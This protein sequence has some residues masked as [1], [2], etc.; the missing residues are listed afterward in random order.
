M[1]VDM[2]IDIYANDADYACTVCGKQVC[3]RCA[4]SNLGAD[5]RCLICAGKR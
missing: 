3:H 1:D 5:R 4:I 2:D